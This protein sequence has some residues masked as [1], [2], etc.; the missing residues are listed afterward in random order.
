MAF[1]YETTNFFLESHEKPEI[2]R[3]DGGHIKINPKVSVIDRSQLSPQLAIELMRFSIIAGRAFVTG[4]RKQGIEIGRINY[5]DNGNW[6]P[7]FHLHLYGRA[8]A[9]TQQKFGDPVIPGHKD[10]YFPL[11]REDIEGIKEEIIKL[12]QQPEFRDDVWKL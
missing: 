4:M 1:I 6:K 5:Q 7:E 11:T 9:A 3:L 12:F 10:T 8:R 2:D